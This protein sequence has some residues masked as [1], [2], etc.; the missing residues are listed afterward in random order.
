MR[1]KKKKK[2]KK[3]GRQVSLSG[4]PIIT[5]GLIEG[6][7]DGNWLN[8]WFIVA[9]RRAFSRRNLWSKKEVLH[10]FWIF[11]HG[12]CS[13]NNLEL[14]FFKFYFFQTG[15]LLWLVSFTAKQLHQWAR[16]NTWNCTQQKAAAHH[17]AFN[18]T[19]PIN[20]RLIRLTSSFGVASRYHY[21]P[22]RQH[23]ES[24][25]FFF[26]QIS[27]PVQRDRTGRPWRLFCWRAQRPQKWAETRGMCVSA[28]GR[29][30]KIRD[31]DPRKNR[32]HFHIVR[33]GPKEA[34]GCHVILLFDSGYTNKSQ[35]RS[36][37]KH[38][39]IIGCFFF[40]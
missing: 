19:K 3:D 30:W 14:D 7:R 1:K 25:H 13:S 40:F 28:P 6:R 2:K 36:V 31:G 20:I 12:G 32:P 39:I 18:M 33:S 5:S 21:G 22:F 17:L 38:K 34:T 10:D 29:W 4:K 8:P 16:R 23:S 15:R 24:R 37:D 26:F 35:H 9:C 11:L 27:V